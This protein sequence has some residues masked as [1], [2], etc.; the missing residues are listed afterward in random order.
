[1]TSICQKDF[2]KKLPFSGYIAQRRFK[3]SLGTR[4]LIGKSN[5]KKKMT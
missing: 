5:A 3:S 2:S 1:M 4:K